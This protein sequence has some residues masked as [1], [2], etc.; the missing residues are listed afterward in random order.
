M[1]LIF[2]VDKA[3]GEA[4]GIEKIWKGGKCMK[5]KVI[6]G[7]VVMFLFG[8]F[9]I[10]HLQAAEPTKV[11]I[12]HIKKLFGPVVFDHKK[13]AAKDGLKIDCITCHHEMKEGKA[14]KGCQTC[15]GEAAK[16]KVVSLKDA[17][18]K[19]CMDCHKVKKG[20]APVK[21]ADCHPKK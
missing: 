12:E 14:V 7:L 18:H 16:G 5:K 21:C 19:V 20:K 15:H 8:P 17:Y 6:I 11:T 13:H 4:N 2:A 9:V 10:S 1:G 3:P